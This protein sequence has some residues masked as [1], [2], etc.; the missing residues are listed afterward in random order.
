MLTKKFQAMSKMTTWG[1]R[2]KK[3]WRVSKAN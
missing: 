2:W 3:R 1:W